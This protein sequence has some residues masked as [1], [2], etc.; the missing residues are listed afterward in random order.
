MNN[1][2]ERFLNENKI[3]GCNLNIDC[4]N[5]GSL[6]Y[7]NKRNI[8]DIKESLGKKF[9]NLQIKDDDGL[10]YS[11]SLVDI[12]DNNAELNVEFQYISKDSCCGSDTQ[13]KDDI[14]VWNFKNER[15]EGFL[16]QNGYELLN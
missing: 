10:V 12:N 7:E 14:L 15:L 1:I 5:D 3:K 8:A 13:G 9:I 6:D 16:F 2:A 4:F 11:L